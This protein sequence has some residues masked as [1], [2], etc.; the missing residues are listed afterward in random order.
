M[1]KCGYMWK[2]I[3]ARLP[4]RIGESVRQRYVNYL[5]PTLK[6]S[7]WTMA[8]DKVLFEAHR[9]LGN[10]WSEIRKLLPGRSENSIKNRYNNKKNVQLRKMKRIQKR[11]EVDKNRNNHS[12]VSSMIKTELDN[13][14]STSAQPPAMHF[15]DFRDDVADRI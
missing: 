13:L 9:K 8:E 5:D 14:P 3:A 15:E 1:V 2:D 6:R 12:S 7:K 4:G 10:R 11:L